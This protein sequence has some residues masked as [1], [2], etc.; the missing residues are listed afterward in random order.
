MP[1]SCASPAVPPVPEAELVGTRWVLETIAQGGTATAAVGEA[2]LEL[3]EDGTATFS[4]GCP[5]MNGTWTTSGDTVL[6][7]DLAF[8]PIPCPPPATPEQDSLV[9]QTLSGG[10]QVTIDGDVLTVTNVDTRGGHS[11]TLVYRAS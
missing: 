7:A 5:T 6:L 2:V 11:V 4:T 9:T 1:G 10:F 8:E 3:R